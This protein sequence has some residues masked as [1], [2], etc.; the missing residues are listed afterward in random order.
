ML[1]TPSRVVGV[2]GPSTPERASFIL[3]RFFSIPA[4]GSLQQVDRNGREKGAALN[5]IYYHIMRGMCEE[6]GLPRVTFNNRKIVEMGEGK[7]LRRA[8]FNKPLISWECGKK[9][10]CLEPPLRP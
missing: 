6:K 7:G 1:Q 9:R 8:T 4:M 2:V 5:Y 3:F 10:G